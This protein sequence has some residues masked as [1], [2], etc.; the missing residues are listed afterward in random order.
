MQ[1]SIGWLG[2]LER[3]PFPVEARFADP[4]HAAEVAEVF[5][6]ELLRNGT[7]TALILATVQ[8][9][10]VDAFFRAAAARRLRMIAGKVLMDRNAPDLLLDTPKS[11]YADSRALIERWQ[12]RRPARLRH[13][14]ALCADLDRGPAGTGRQASRRTFRRLRPHACGREPQRGRLGRRAGPV[15]PQLPGCLRPLRPASPPS[16]GR[17]HSVW[18]TASA[19]YAPARRPTSSCWTRPRHR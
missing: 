10:S 4:A 9:Q 2:W 11:G 19:T 15:E 16:A 8:P 17:A 1:H 3:Y 5:L 13:H 6:D 18:M 14:A 7:T 12:G